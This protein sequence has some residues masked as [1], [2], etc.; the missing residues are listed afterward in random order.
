MPYLVLASSLFDWSPLH[1]RLGVL[2]VSPAILVLKDPRWPGQPGDGQPG[3]RRNVTVTIIHLSIAFSHAVIVPSVTRI[4]TR[5]VSPGLSS[6]GLST[7]EDNGKR[8]KIR[9]FIGFSSDA[10]SIGYETNSSSSVQ[11]RTIR[12]ANAVVLV[13]NSGDSR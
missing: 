7:V 11:L 8:L 5:I 12:W 9:G 6:P 13:L 4:V 10:R 3:D 1:P 2:F